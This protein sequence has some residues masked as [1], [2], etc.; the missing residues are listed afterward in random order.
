MAPQPI[1]TSVTPATFTPF[2]KPPAGT[3]SNPENPQS[4]VHLADI[5]IAVCLPLVTIFFL[6]RCYVRLFMKRVWILEDYLVTISWAGAV[7]YC[8][9]MRATM[10]HHGGEHGWDITKAQAQEASYWFNVT[11]IEYGAIIGITKCALLMFYRRVF[12][13]VRRSPFDIT[14][15]AL[16]VIMAGFYGSNTFLKIFECTPRSKIWNSAIPGRCVDLVMVLNV[17]GGFNAVSDLVILL[18][19]VHAVSKLQMSNSKRVLAILAFTFGLWY[20][21]F[22]SVRCYSEGRVQVDMLP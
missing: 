1:Q 2:L 15:I 8:A 3:T 13:P 6:G 18:L 11:A 10:S 20:V 5:T 9:V 14:L 12:S 4:L 21:L 17:S 7:G 19:P 22:P 16:M